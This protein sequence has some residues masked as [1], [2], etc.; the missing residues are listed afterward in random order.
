MLAQKELGGARTIGVIVAAEAGEVVE[1]EGGQQVGQFIQ[2]FLDVG[3]G[4]LDLADGLGA[5]AL[6]ARLVQSF[7]SALAVARDAPDAVDGERDHVR[8]P[9]RLADKT[10]PGHCFPFHDPT[11]VLIGPGGGCA[12][13][14]RESV[15]NPGGSGT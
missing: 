8:V 10:Q 13:H 3:H 12:Q 7:P 11:G 5:G 14:V 6:G 9:L 2:V 1:G 15:E 4:L